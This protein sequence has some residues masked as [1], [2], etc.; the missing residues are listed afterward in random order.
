M[1]GPASKVKP[2]CLWTVGSAPGSV[3]LFENGDAVAS[4]AQSDS[5]SEAA[6]T[7]SDDDRSGAGIDGG[8]A[9]RAL[10][11][12]QHSDT[13][14]VSINTIKRNYNSSPAGGVYA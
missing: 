3:E 13:L 1:V 9:D 5:R 4:G 12:C 10:L 6:E 8:R 11:K 14:E 7:A 2:S